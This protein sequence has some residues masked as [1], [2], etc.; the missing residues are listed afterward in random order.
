MST[1]KQLTG[2]R[3][4]RLFFNTTMW[5]MW[6]V[7]IASVAA[8]VFSVLTERWILTATAGVALVLTLVL[9]AVVLSKSIRR[10]LDGMSLVRMLWLEAMIPMRKL[11]RIIRYKRA[12]K[13]DFISH[14]I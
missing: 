8:V 11:A 3:H 2:T 6:I 14:K 13:Y 5:A 1:R 9:R 10:Y 12:D 4:C 7:Y